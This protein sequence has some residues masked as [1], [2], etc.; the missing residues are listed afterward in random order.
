M[1]FCVLCVFWL[2]WL[3][4]YIGLLEEEVVKFNKIKLKINGFLKEMKRVCDDLE[5]IIEMEKLNIGKIDK[6]VDL[7][8]GMI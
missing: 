7:I 8:L 2:Y 4:K 6:N 3:C 1:F 5:K